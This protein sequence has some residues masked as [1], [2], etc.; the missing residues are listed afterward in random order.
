MSQRGDPL[1]LILDNLVRYTFRLVAKQPH[2]TI[3]KLHVPKADVKLPRDELFEAVGAT[4][5]PSEQLRA[6]D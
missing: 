2:A 5:R 4:R 6:A 3:P 1:L